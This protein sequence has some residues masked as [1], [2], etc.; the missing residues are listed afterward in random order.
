MNCPL[1]TDETMLLDYAAGRLDEDTASSLTRHMSQCVDCAAWSI[2]QSAVWEMLDN[3]E[4][5]P[6]SVDFNRRLWQRIDAAE[7]APWYRRLAESLRF[8]NWKPAFPLAAAVVLVAGGF[9]LDQ[10]NTT[11]RQSAGAQTVTTSE[12]EQVE[13]TL[14]DLQLLHQLDSATAAAASKQM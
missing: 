11:E 6:V 14:D 9:V 10:R 8:A 2:E 3:L 7:S 5:P 13:Q 1:T 12:A 4:P